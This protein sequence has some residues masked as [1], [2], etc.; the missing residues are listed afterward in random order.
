M[1]CEGIRN[2]FSEYLDQALDAEVRNSVD[3]HLARCPACRTELNRL[4]AA[5]KLL[6]RLPEIPAPPDF[7]VSVRNRLDAVPAWRRVLD[8]IPAF[9]PGLLRPVSLAASFALVF[10]FA[11]IVGREYPPSHQAPIELAKTEAP[12]GA[13]TAP[14]DPFS[15]IEWT[16]AAEPEAPRAMAVSLGGGFRVPDP[17]EVEYAASRSRESGSFPYQTPTEFVVALIKADPELRYADIYPLP[18][19]ALALLPDYLYQITIS[20]AG[21]RQA[22][23]TFA[24]TGHQV[25]RSLG[26]ALQLYPL[27]VRRLVSPLSPP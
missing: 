18:Q 27:Q 22:S 12:A 10:T 16:I 4:A 14:P 3:E 2:R 17:M 13:W 21:F 20:D 6:A 23:K 19:G 24:R 11:F 25:P 9:R 8:S 5:V 7:L 26:N 1:N 15:G